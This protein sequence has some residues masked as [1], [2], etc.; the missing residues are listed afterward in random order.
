MA[1]KL[2]AQVSEAFWPSLCSTLA[3]EKPGV[4]RGTMK[5]DRPFLP[6]EGSVTANTRVRPAM[7]AEVMNCLE[8]SMT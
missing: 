8:P 3:I 2:S 6:A 7:R 1:S 4:P 5:A